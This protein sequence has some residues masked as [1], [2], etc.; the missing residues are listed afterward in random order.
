MG[1]RR[2]VE[3]ALFVKRSRVIPFIV[4]C[5]GGITPH[6]RAH[7]S[8]LSRRARSRDATKYGT[9]RTSTTS[10]YVHHVQRVAVAAKQ[11][12]AKAIMKSIRC[13]KQKLVGGTAVGSH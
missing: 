11:Y 4:E 2:V 5:Q 7:I 9:S 12:D 10:Y 3:D 1:A 8:H 13:R 6:A